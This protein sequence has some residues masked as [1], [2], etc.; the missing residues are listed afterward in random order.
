MVDASGEI[1][2]LVEGGNDNA[3]LFHAFFLQVN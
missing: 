2:C 1:L 3:D